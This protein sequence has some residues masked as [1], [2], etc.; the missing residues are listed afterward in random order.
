MSVHR[1]R[2]VWRLDAP[3]AAFAAGRYDRAHRLIF[4][5]GLEVAGSAS[6]AVVPAPFS[7]AD[8]L[9]PE[10]AFTGA[11][12]ACH[13]LWFLDLARQAGLVVSA[14]EDAAE[15][16][17]AR[18]PEGRMAITR[19]TLRPRVAWGGS[20]QPRSAEIAALHQAAHE[21]CFIANSVRTEVIVAPEG[22]ESRREDGA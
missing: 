4:E 2:V 1:A 18:D 3:D 9:D 15:G 20:R 7:R 22:G 14:Y 19:V 21:A 11:L 13:M 12:S 16:T 8:A 6:P 5:A 17:L 10:A